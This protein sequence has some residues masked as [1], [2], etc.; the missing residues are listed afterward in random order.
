MRYSSSHYR[1]EYNTAKWSLFIVGPIFHFSI[2]NVKQHFL[3]AGFENGKWHGWNTKQR[4]LFSRPNVSTFYTTNRIFHLTFEYIN[5]QILTS[6]VV[7]V[8][9]TLD[10]RRCDDATYSVFQNQIHIEC[11]CMR[12]SSMTVCFMWL[13]YVFGVCFFFSIASATVIAKTVVTDAIMWW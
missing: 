7:K 12:W 11:Q 5:N 10:C 9:L 4:H 3:F 13:T 1:N 6:L 2:L 8:M